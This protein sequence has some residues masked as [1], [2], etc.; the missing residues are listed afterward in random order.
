M[1][2]TKLAIIIAIGLTLAPAQLLAQGVGGSAL[3]PQPGDRAAPSGAVGGSARPATSGERIGPSGGSG[4]GGSAA[5]ANPGAPNPNS[6]MG[7]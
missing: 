1:F 5:P 3:P 6:A 2:K 4:V 7:R